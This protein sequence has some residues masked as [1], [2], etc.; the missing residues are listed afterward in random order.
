[1][2]MES[3]GGADQIAQI[4]TPVIKER[5]TGVE[6]H[7][8]QTNK[9]GPRGDADMG[10]YEGHMDAIEVRKAAAA[11]QTRLTSSRVCFVTLPSPEVSR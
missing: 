2:L 11:L 3:Q 5:P 6:P 9:A 10:A 8:V 7:M 4:N 1:M